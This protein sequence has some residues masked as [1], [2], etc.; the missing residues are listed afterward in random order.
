M[1]FLFSKTKSLRLKVSFK[2]KKIFTG[3]I[4]VDSSSLLPSTMPE[5]LAALFNEFEA[6]ALLAEVEA[7]AL[8]AEVEARAF[9]AEAEEVQLSAKMLVEA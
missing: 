6:G 4:D 1:R 7:R 3:G 9:S 2:G 5:S 8:S